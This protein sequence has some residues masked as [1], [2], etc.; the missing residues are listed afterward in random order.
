MK[1]RFLSQ[2]CKKEEIEELIKEKEKRTK[3]T[4][5]LK[6]TKKLQHRKKIIVYFFVY[7]KILTKQQQKTQILIS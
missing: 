6:K 3:E 4:G 5:E 2:L 1:I 7:K